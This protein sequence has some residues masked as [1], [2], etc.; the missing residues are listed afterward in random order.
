MAAAGRLMRP[1]GAT[2]ATSGL[3]HAAT[4]S[5]TTTALRRVAIAHPVHVVILGTHPGPRLP[6]ILGLGELLEE[7]GGDQSQVGLASE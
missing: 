1:L 3:H 5:I 2:S 7:R 4:I 6:V